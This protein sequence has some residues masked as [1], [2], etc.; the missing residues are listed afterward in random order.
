MQE[1]D[2][3]AD[4]CCLKLNVGFLTVSVILTRHI[5]LLSRCDV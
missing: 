4:I 3:T 1:K 2:L 5:P